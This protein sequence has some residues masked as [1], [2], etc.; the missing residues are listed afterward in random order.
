MV[1]GLNVY[2]GVPP[3]PPAPAGFPT[4]VHPSCLPLLFLDCHSVL[5][6]SSCVSLGGFCLV[7]RSSHCFHPPSRRGSYPGSGLAP[8]SSSMLITFGLFAQFGAISSP[9]MSYHLLF[10]GEGSLAAR[11]MGCSSTGCPRASFTVP[12]SQ[13]QLDFYGGVFYPISEHLAWLL[14]IRSSGSAGLVW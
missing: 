14:L 6:T 2:A 9:R 7:S 3:F 5:F 10:W 8:H 12:S 11:S 13:Q 4:V 1:R